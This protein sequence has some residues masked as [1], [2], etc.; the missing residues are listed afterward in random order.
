MNTIYQTTI[1]DK[2]TCDYLDF[3]IN[4]VFVLLP[5]FEESMISE[6]KNKSHA[7]YQKNL[8]QMI[9]GNTELIKYDN[10]TVIDILSNLQS[11]FK[12]SDHNDYKRHILKVCNLL[13]ELK[14]EVA[15]NGI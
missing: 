15:D 12:A 8:I 13:S 11:L 7:I 6:E 10:H 14:K 2:L 9:N 5:M 4:K 1:P 3:L